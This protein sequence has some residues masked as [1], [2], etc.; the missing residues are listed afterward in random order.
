MHFSD[1]F[2][3]NW[4]EILSDMSSENRL[5]FSEYFSKVNEKIN[6]FVTPFAFPESFENESPNHLIFSVKDSIYTRNFP[7]TC[8]L[9]ELKN[10]I[11][12]ND[13]STVENLISKGFS[14]VGKTNLPSNCSG[15]IT[16]NIL[17]GATK[18][19]WDLTKNSGGSSGGS[20]ASVAAGFTHFS[21]CSDY[22]GSA[23]LPSHL[24]GVYSLKPTEYTTD[25][26]YHIPPCYPGY[27]NFLKHIGVLGIIASSLETIKSV[28]PLVQNGNN[29]VKQMPSLP[30]D[31]LKIAHFDPFGG[32]MKL[33]STVNE[34]YENFTSSV[35]KSHS[36]EWISRR[37]YT[38]GK[39]NDLLLEIFGYEYFHCVPE[40]IA[41][42]LHHI[43]K[44]T[45]KPLTGF[46]KG[47][48]NS[49]DEFAM[50]LNNKTKI[51]E[52]VCSIL[53]HYDIIMT[54]VSH[55]NNIDMIP[56]PN[57]VAFEYPPEFYRFAAN[58]LLFSLSGHPSIS[59]PL[60]IGKNGI[61]FSAM[62]IGQ[63]N[64]ESVLIDA[65][66]KI[67][68]RALENQ[69]PTGIKNHLERMEFF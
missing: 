10:F 45:D 31:N 9:P 47:I 33:S 46:L 19:P 64:S 53:E 26:G 56:R 69:I 8:G 37:L 17:F 21:I 58:T 40:S 43:A 55:T 24:C 25:T 18:N 4:D 29:P 54:P 5:R 38:P 60:G 42:G 16:D 41:Q 12:G 30:K 14:L 65:A 7:T 52:T 35:G 57:E 48:L 67:N 63:K 44:S 39:L 23:H 20:A 13:H 36:I 62:L 28:F 59:I 3:K 2:N 68:P 11:P 61:P 49:E 51:S 15:I 6:A 27:R 1:I 66:M 34:L 22:G 32:E 50:C